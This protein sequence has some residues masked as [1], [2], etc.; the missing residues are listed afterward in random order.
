[1]TVRLWIGL[2]PGSDVPLGR[3]AA[4]QPRDRARDGPSEPVWQPRPG[5]LK[6]NAHAR[7][8][9]D[10]LSQHSL[11]GGATVVGPAAFPTGRIAPCL[12][13]VA[14]GRRST[15]IAPLVGFVPVNTDTS[16]HFQRNIKTRRR[17]HQVGYGIAALVDLTLRHF[18]NQF[19]VD[20]H[21]H[22]TIRP[23]LQ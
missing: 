4:G 1:M 6:R 16:V 18:E 13:G 22:L 7:E 20:L 14:D 11:L 21:D 19:I 8:Y 5:A 23:L 17:S 9:R 15:A 10:Q 3:L 2:E 12:A